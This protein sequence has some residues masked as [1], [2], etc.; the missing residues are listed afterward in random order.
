MLSIQLP[1]EVGDTALKT[2]SIGELFNL[3]FTT[4]STAAPATLY[5]APASWG[6]RKWTLFTDAQAQRPGPRTIAAGDLRTLEHELLSAKAF[7]SRRAEGAKSMRCSPA[8]C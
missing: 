6:E 4:Q 2:C 7:F 3:P 1:F 8:L 5:L